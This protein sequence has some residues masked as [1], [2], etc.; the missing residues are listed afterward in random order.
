MALRLKEKV[1]RR[2]VT[3]YEEARAS[4]EGRGGLKQ[5]INYACLHGLLDLVDNRGEVLDAIANLI[6]LQQDSH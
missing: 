3:G 4:A 6:K 2:D 5:A 1:E